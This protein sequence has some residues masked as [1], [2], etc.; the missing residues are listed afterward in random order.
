M[1]PT[2]MVIGAQKAATTTLDAHLREHPDIA[3]PRGL[4][5]TNFLIDEGNWHRGLEWYESLWEEAGDRPHRGEV[6]PGY[7]MFPTFRR[8]PERAAQ[9]CPQA[10][11]VYL[12]RHPVDRMISSWIQS[13]EWGLEHRGLATALLESRRYADLSSYGMQ[14]AHWLEHF[15]REQVLVLRTD[16]LADSYGDAL[17]RLLAHLGLPTG[18]RPSAQA[19]RL[20]ESLDKRAPRGPAR[21][22]ARALRATGR[23]G[24]ANRLATRG[25]RWMRRPLTQAETQL[26]PELRSD[27]AA[28]FRADLAYLRTLVGPDVD[29]WGLA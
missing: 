7:T 21:L 9:L 28:T 1:L 2:F 24:A 22:A 29:L 8:A 20:N 6:S 4:K 14:L 5:E 13:T 27:L 25:G 23:A 17:D 10:R 11:L 18:W 3:M 12:I 16:D 15:D 26:T 19:P